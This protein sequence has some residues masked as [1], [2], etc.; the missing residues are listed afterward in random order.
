MGHDETTTR[1]ILSG[2]QPVSTYRTVYSIYGLRVADDTDR[3]RIEEELGQCIN[4]GQ[5][6]VFWAGAHDRPM[7]FLAVKWS[8]VQPGE[9]VFH[10]GEQPNEHLFVRNRWN[11]DL[12][13]SADRLGLD[14][15]GEPGWYTIP[16]ES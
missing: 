2:G 5:P 3:V 13:A 9:Y 14:V 4:D 12:R 15:T 16:S 11:S 7:T 8:S 10:S 1:M 6:G